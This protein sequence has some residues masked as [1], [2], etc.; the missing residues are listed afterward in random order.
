MWKTELPCFL[1]PVL[2]E[3]GCSDAITT[4][5]FSQIFWK[6]IKNILELIMENK[7]S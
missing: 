5:S 3:G 4:V 7:S 2:A 6:N 1:P